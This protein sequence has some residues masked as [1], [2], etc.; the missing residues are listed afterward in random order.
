MILPKVPL[1]QEFIFD[2]RL[3]FLVLKGSNCNTQGEQNPMAIHFEIRKISCKML[4]LFVGIL[5]FRID[6]HK[7]GML[8]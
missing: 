2:I 3:F 7:L 8:M 1:P 4:L 5:T 6:L